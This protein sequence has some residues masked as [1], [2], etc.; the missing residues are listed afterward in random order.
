MKTNN[1]PSWLVSVEIAEKLKKIGFNT[2]TVFIYNEENEPKIMFGLNTFEEVDGQSNLEIEQLC[3]QQEADMETY[4]CILPT[5]EQVFAWFNGKELFHS[6]NIAN[7]IP[8]GK[9]FRAKIY[10][11]SGEIIKLI[12]CETYEEAREELVNKLIKM[13]E[14]II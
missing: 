10:K 7:E 14:N 6:I 12:D 3:L 8:K 9:Y 4:E 11:N 1:Y 5:W 2:N 13:Y